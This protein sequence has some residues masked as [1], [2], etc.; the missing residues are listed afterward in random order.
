ML[1][2][3]IAN[4]H[5]HRRFLKRD[6]PPELIADLIQRLGN[7]P[8]GGNKQL[9]EFTL[10]D[11]RAQMDTFRTLAY[12]KMER[13][14]ARGVFPAGY[15]RESYDAL[16]RWE[17]AV[18]PEML[19][20]SAPYLLV[21]HAPRGAGEPEQDVTVAAVYFELLCASRGLGAVLMSFPRDVLALMPEVCALLGIPADHVIGVMIGFGWPEVRY[22]RGSQRGIEPTRI[23]RPRF[24]EPSE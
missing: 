16:K 2:A 4:R 1:D 9:V 19:F 17:A 3:L 23:H 13:L 8:N 21:P 14:A 22:A 10:I 6:V 11:D 18:R 20:C 24:P 7:A 12:G 15:D 5:S